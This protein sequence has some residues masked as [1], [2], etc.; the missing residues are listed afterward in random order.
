LEQLAV[1]ADNLPGTTSGEIGVGAGAK[2]GDADFQIDSRTR[3]GLSQAEAGSGSGRGS[4]LRCGPARLETTQLLSC[5]SG[6]LRRGRRIN[7]GIQQLAL[8]GPI[9]AGSQALGRKSHRH[10][11]NGHWAS[12]HQSP[13]EETTQMKSSCLEKTSVLE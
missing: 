3:F 13:A 4:C 11:H 5:G 12:Q 10:S 7:K 8:G 6:V 9:G 1:S 2:Q